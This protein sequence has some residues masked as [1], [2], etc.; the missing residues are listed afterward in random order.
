MVRL[1]NCT[2]ILVSTV[3]ISVA[4]QAEKRDGSMYEHKLV[5]LFPSWICNIL[6]HIPSTHKQ[7]RRQCTVLEIVVHL[8]HNLLYWL[9]AK[10]TIYLPS[11]G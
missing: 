8:V 11:H 5:V 2:R 3:A 10:F 6:F 9:E 7:I 4:G 1:S